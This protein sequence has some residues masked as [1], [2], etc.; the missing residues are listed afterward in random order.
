MGNVAL[1]QTYVRETAQA[2]NALLRDLQA[3]HYDL[4]EQIAAMEATTDEPRHDPVHLASARWKISQASL[5]RRILAGRICEYLL[6]RCEAQQ[7]LAI[8]ALQE[9]DRLLLQASAR[10]VGQWRAEHIKEDWRGYCRASREVRRQMQD[11]VVLEQKVLYG[12]LE[13]AIQ[14][15]D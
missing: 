9:A 5:A 7:M 1:A 8:K 3:V 13:R 15:G 2:A 12:I 14:L 4:H 6:S 10:H 11:H